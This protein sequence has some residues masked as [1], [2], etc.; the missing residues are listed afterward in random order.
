MVSNYITIALHVHRCLSGYLKT[1]ILFFSS[2]EIVFQPE[3]YLY[4]A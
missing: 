4:E 1:H 3:E 2:L